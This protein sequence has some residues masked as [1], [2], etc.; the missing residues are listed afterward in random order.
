L[1]DQVKLAYLV[2]FTDVTVASSI[3]GRAAAGAVE[4]E[5]AV[6]FLICAKAV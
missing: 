2:F 1:V 4:A 6:S 3:S 5:V